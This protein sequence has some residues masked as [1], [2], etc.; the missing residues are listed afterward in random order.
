MQIQLT[1]PILFVWVQ[2]VSLA[3]LAVS[4]FSTLRGLGLVVSEAECTGS[5]VGF[6]GLLVCFAVVIVLGRLSNIA[7][8]SDNLIKKRS[9][10]SSH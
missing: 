4:N 2:S 5:V 8:E 10:Y 6:T 7:S 1:M 3:S 9:R